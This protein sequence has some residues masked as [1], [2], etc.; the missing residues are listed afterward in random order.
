MSQSRCRNLCRT[1]TLEKNLL[2]TNLVGYDSQLNIL[3]EL[4]LERL[5]VLLLQVPHVVGH[6]LPEDVRAVHLSIE[7]LV[8]GVVAGEPLDRVGNVQAPVDGPLHGA[9]DAGAG[10]SAL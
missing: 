10:R 3:A 1:Y 4:T 9:E 7:A 2:N 6:V 5:R 8:L